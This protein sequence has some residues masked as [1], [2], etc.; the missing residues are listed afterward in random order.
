MSEQI[1][2]LLAAARPR[3]LKPAHSKTN[4]SPLRI[5][6]LSPFSF[7]NEI[8]H[9]FLLYDRWGLAG[10]G[11]RVLA[12]ISSTPWVTASATQTTQKKKAGRSRNLASVV[13][14]RVPSALPTCFIY[15]TLRD[16]LLGLTEY[17]GNDVSAVL[18]H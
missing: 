15:L 10:S 17:L 7:N 18:F 13:P 12:G 2:R 14:R 16:L 11:A 4:V 3:S 6:D 1:A 8:D 9:W 5:V